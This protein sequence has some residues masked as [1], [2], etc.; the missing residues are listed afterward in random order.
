MMLSTENM[1]KP[2]NTKW[3]TLT[4]FGIDFK[5]GCYCKRFMLIYIP[6][7]YHLFDSPSILQLLLNI[8]VE[9]MYTQHEV[10]VLDIVEAEDEQGN[11]YF[12][13]T[14]EYISPYNPLQL[15]NYFQE[16]QTLKELTN[17]I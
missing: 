5:T 10:Q 17:I 11:T 7:D 15:T 8:V 2:E 14:E 6:Q 3:I 13:E 12:N 9:P 16:Q 4:L 1:N